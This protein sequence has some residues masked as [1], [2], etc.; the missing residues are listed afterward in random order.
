MLLMVFVVYFSYET[1]WTLIGKVVYNVLSR[2][3]FIIGFFMTCLPIM[4]GNLQ[5]L[6]GW[7]GSDFFQPLSKVSFALYVIHPFVIR[8]IYYNFRHAIY[9]EMSFLFLYASSFIFV[10]YILSFFV[11]A[12]FETPFMHLRKLL[13]NRQVK[14]LSKVD[15]TTD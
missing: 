10:T 7:M 2:K 3:G 4:Q 9:F 6:G 8:Y 15:V 14:T 11:T 12:I 13:D 5:T 1:E